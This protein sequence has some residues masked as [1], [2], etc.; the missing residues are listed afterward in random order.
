MLYVAGHKFASIG[1]KV[2]DLNMCKSKVRVACFPRELVSFIHARELNCFD[3]LS[4][5]S[6]P[7]WKMH[8]RWEV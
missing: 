8:L 1:F 5:M 3:T 2:P 7:N 4:D 6:L